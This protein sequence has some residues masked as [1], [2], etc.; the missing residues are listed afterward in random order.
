MNTAGVRCLLSASCLA[1]LMPLCQAQSDATFTWAIG[2]F[3]AQVNVP[4]AMLVSARINGKPCDLQL[5][6]G[7]AAP[8]AWHTSPETTASVDVTVRL[9]G[10][11]LRVP[12][13]EAARQLISHCQAGVPVGSIGNGFFDQGTLTLD[14]G[15]RH[16]IYR[17]GS[18]LS[19]DASVHPFVYAS[20]GAEGGQVQVEVYWGEAPSHA[21]LD[22]GSTALSFGAFGASRWTH[23]TGRAPHEGD[24]VQ[25]FEVPAWGQMHRCFMALSTTPW[26]VGD[27]T[28]GSSHITYCP[29][30]GEN[31]PASV[32][33]VV[34]MQAFPHSRITIDYPGRR[35]QVAPSDCGASRHTQTNAG[36][37]PCTP[38]R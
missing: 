13:A 19:P 37:S 30:I 9:L 38:P 16:I 10:R 12:A 7:M 5:D 21:L 29:S 4:V 22:T 14:T 11:T 36:P 3:A 26:Q 23:L 33:G 15:R 31:A 32:A 17:P 6:T 27:R 34:G 24:G 2:T 1:S 35:W 25:T 18:R 20:Q 8:L 28:I